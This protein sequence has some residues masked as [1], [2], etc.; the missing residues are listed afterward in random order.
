MNKLNPLKNLRILNTRPTAQAHTFSQALRDAGG[1]SI[2][3]PTITIVPTARD[4]IT[5][6]PPRASF[7]YAIFI[8]PN[9]VLHFFNAEPPSSWP[10]TLQTIA[11][12]N[13]TR[14]A[15]AHRGINVHLVPIY[16]D[17][18]HLLALEALQ[19]IQSKTILLIKGKDGRTLI[20]DTLIQR[21]AQVT[22]AAVYQRSCPP[23]DKKRTHTLWQEDA[24]DMI[25]ITSQ[26]AMQHLFTLFEPAARTWLCSK[27]FLVISP[28]LAQI[29]AEYGIKTT[30]VSRHD[31]LMNT[32]QEVFT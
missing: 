2:E 25:L 15:C 4:W 31:A 14:R 5:C 9:A 1:I 17:S 20:E 10:L 26:Q 6:L 23:I 16:A 12:G 27:P 3:L 28:R 32:L 13:G 29:A 24:V 11:I 30:F 19:H 21:G 22:T 8:S 18:E 7:A